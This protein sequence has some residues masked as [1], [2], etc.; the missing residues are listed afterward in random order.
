MNSMTMHILGALVDAAMKS[1]T[2]GCRSEVI[3]RTSSLNPFSISLLILS[4][5]M[6]LTATSVPFQMAL[7]TSP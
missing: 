1:T 6:T 3:T 7:C 2:F 4:D 5:A